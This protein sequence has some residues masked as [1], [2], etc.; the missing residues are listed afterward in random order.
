MR[1]HFSIIALAVILFCGCNHASNDI[2]PWGEISSFPDWWLNKYKPTPITRTLHVNFNEDALAEFERDIVLALYQV[3]EQGKEVPVTPEQV[4]LLVDGTP[5]PDNKLTIGKDDSDIQIG[6]LI[7]KEF[8]NKNHTGTLNWRFKVIDNGGLDYINEYEVSGTEDTKPLLRDQTAMNVY[9][10][11]GKNKPHVITDLSLLIILAAIIAFIIII[12]IVTP[13]FTNNQLRKIFIT[14]EGSRKGLPNMCRDAKGAKEI[15]ITGK[16]GMSQSFIKRLFTCRSSY[17]FIKGL[18]GDIIL[19]PGKRFQ[20]KARCS[21]Q[22]YEIESLGDN[23]ELKRI[24]GNT[25]DGI[26]VEVEY[27]AKRS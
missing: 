22:L 23:N 26:P 10:E 5:V 18:P 1:K 3:N 25:Q 4:Q 27:F 20:T 24:V 11:R 8:L 21:R 15:I 13:K 17:I 14:V 9:H 7:Q 16:K 19:T 2:A 12:N 6:L